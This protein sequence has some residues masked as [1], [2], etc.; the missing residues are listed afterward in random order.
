MLTLKKPLSIIRCQKTHFV[1]GVTKVKSNIPPL[2]VGIGDISLKTN[3]YQLNKSKS[4]TLEY[5]LKNNKVTSLDKPTISKTNI[6]IISSTQTSGAVST[7][8]DPNLKRY[9]REFSKDVSQKLWLPTK[10]DLQD[11]DTHYLNGFLNN[12]TQSSFVTNLNQQKLKMN[13]PKTL[14]LSSQYLL[15]DTM[16]AENIKKEIQYCKKIRF[17]PTTEFKSLAEQ[18]FG[19]TRYIINKAIEG[20]NKKEIT[21]VTSHITLRK[22][23]L[24][25]NKELLLPENKHELWLKNIPYDTRQLALKQ[26][27]SNYKTGFTQLKNKTIT[28]F[29][30]KYKSRRNPY[31]Y[32][33]I[34]HRALKPSQMKIFSRKSKKPFRLRKKMKKWWSKYILDSKQDI[35]IRREKNRYYMCIPR[36]KKG[37][38]NEQFKYKHKHNCV[39]LDPG[40]RT[41]QTIYSEEGVVGKLGHNAC[42][43]LI[44]KGLKVDKLTSYL[45]TNKTIKKKTRYRLRRRCFLLRTKIKN[46]V[47]DLHWKTASYLCGT[48]KHILLPKFE[49]SNMTRKGLP[50]KARVINS[51][52][53]RKMLSLSHYKF[54]QRMLYLSRVY[55]SHVYICNE[56]Y[57]T[58]ACGGCGLLKQK[59][60]GAKVYRCTDCNFEIDRDYN[61]ARNIYM[62][63]MK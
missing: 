49:V 8:K 42:D 25:S 22:A 27:A 1:H 43:D 11:S 46:K 62:K 52:T 53:V 26:L 2:K 19:A 30:M 58:S 45:K 4:Y 24:K 32:F 56:S 5:H 15:P 10:T 47:N 20:I 38:N 13:Y 48:Y 6:P 41:F 12:T 55:G 16:E 37:W 3:K 31:Q 35:V 7:L 34:D 36:K 9:W 44:T 17:Y 51:K 59:L 63:H 21:K 54:K 14:C 18:C 40:V 60:G 28:K 61:A 33:H 23:V 57:T 29:E 50:E 39:A